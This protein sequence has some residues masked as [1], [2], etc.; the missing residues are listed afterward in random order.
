MRGDNAGITERK[1]SSQI[2]ILWPVPNVLG[3]EMADFAFAK[4][5]GSDETDPDQ[6]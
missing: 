4:K 2:R 3:V 1:Y 6:I 5:G